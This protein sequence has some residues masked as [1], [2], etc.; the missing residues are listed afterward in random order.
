MMATEK[1]IY[2][3]PKNQTTKVVVKLK[4]WN[5][6]DYLDIR[7][8]FLPKNGNTW[9]HSKKGVCMNV[10]MLSPMITALERAEAELNKEEPNAV[11]GIKG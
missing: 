1:Y 6:K 8:Y 7:E 9:I 2:E 5:G 10:A 3:M 11:P 4:P